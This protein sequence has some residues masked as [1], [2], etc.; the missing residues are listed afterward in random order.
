[1]SVDH[2]R[3]MEVV[4]WYFNC[5]LDNWFLFQSQHVF[6]DMFI[7]W[8][9]NILRKR[10][11]YYRDLE[12]LF[13]LLPALYHTHVARGMVSSGIFVSFIKYIIVFLC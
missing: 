9:C 12:A 1:M 5:T 8:Y 11:V 13:M 7:G 3:L 4:F 6:I 2:R 10:P